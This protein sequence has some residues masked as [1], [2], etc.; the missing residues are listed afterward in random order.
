MG[1]TACTEPQCLYS[2]A[3]PLL[4]LGAIRLVQ[5]LSACTRVYF[6]FIYIYIYVCVCIC[7]NFEVTV[8]AKIQNISFNFVPQVTEP[9]PPV[10]TSQDMNENIVQ[11][12]SLLMLGFLSKIF[13]QL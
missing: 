8:I 5:S 12:V 6:T 1:R 3:I 4:P 13:L 7:K 11:S 9:R 10:T 2:R